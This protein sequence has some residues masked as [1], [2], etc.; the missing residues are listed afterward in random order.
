MFKTFE[1]VAPTTTDGHSLP[2][3][4]SDVNPKKYATIHHICVKSPD[5]Q[6]ERPYTPINDVQKDGVMKIVVK[7]VKGGEVGRHIH[8][9][10]EGDKIEIRGPIRT[11]QIPIDEYDHITTISTGTGLTPFLQL[12]SKL[13][14]IP[15]KMPRFTLLHY[16]PKPTLPSSQPRSSSSAL[17]DI[18]EM[19]VVVPTESDGMDIAMEEPF[20]PKAQRD[21]VAGGEGRVLNVQRVR[22]GEVIKEDDILNSF[23][24]VPTSDSEEDNG[25]M[26][27][28]VE[29]EA[30]GWWPSVFGGGGKKKETS[31]SN[32]VKK[33]DLKRK[34]VMVCL[35]VKSLPPLVGPPPRGRDVP[36]LGGILGRLG[37]SRSDIWVL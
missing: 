18:D 16:F 23:E 19:G 30:E 34:A 8:S 21:F 7:R 29:E 2:A 36:P 10:R 5:L 3:S 24:E 17:Q 1:V 4:T 20:I 31:I 33:F 37:F 14:A 6:I 25:G 11:C 9:L 32:E 35:P 15:S 13:S 27:N 28:E 12:F 22:A 26:Y